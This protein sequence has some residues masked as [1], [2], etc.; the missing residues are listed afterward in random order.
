MSQPPPQS[1]APAYGSQPVP[2]AAGPGGSPPAGSM[3]IPS[4]AQMAAPPPTAWQGPYLDATSGRYYYHNPWTQQSSWAQAP[5]A[6][7]PEGAAGAIPAAAY[8]MP[9]MPMGVPGMPPAGYPMMPMPY[10]YPYMAPGMQ[11]AYAGAYGAP[12]PG[13]SQPPIGGPTGGGSTGGSLGRDDG[14]EECGDFKRGKCDRGDTCRYVHVKPTQECRDFRA[15]RC[16]RGANCK[17]LHDG[18]VVAHT[19]ERSR[20]R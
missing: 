5:A 11:A 3:P 14:R 19:R 15:G 20:S 12:A 10:G 8:G 7:P 6:P 17:F 1:P 13:Q 16:T 4:V 18:D 9:A 2:V